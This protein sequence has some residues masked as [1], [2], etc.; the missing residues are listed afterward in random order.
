MIFTHHLPKPDPL[1]AAILLAY[2]MDETLCVDYLLQEL[3]LTEEARE[4][5][6][7]TARTL[8]TEVRKR[9]LHKNGLDAFLYQYDLSSEEG[10]ALMCLAEALLR[11]PD[12]AT[13]A[14]LIRDKISPAAWQAQLG[15]SESFFVNAATWGLMLTGKILSYQTLNE[16]N[17]AVALKKLVSHTSEPV[18]RSAVRHSMKI[19]GHQFVMGQ[20]IESALKR[21]K[22][23]EKL[24]YS[25]SYDMLGEAARTAEDAERYFAAYWHAIQVIGKMAKGKNIYAAPGVSIKLS[26]LYPRYELAQHERCVPFVVE[27]LRELALQAKAFNISF[28][29]D[30]EEADRLELSLDIIE[31]VFTD[32]LLRDWEGF[33]V[34]VQAYQKRAMPLID[35][36]AELARSQHRRLMLRLVKGAYWDYE[37][38]DSQVKGLAG[39]PVFT[40]KRN[41]DVSY[42]ACVKRIA[43]AQDAFFPQFAT[44]NAHTVAAVLEIMGTRRDF[45][46]QCLHGMGYTLYDHIVPLEKKNIPCRVYAPVGGHEDLLSYLVRR[47]LENG[48][49]T[50]FVNRIVDANAPIKG[51]VADPIEMVRHFGS[52]PHPHIPLP[53]AVFGASRQNSRGIDFTD[54]LELENLALEMTTAAKKMWQATPTTLSK[55]VRHLKAEAV[56]SPSNS[57]RQV[58]VVRDA[59]SIEVNLALEYAHHSS[60]AWDHLSI[61]DRAACLERAADLFEQHRAELIT[62][63]VLEAGKCLPDATG[64]VREATDYC[65]YYAQQA[66]EKLSTQTLPGPTGESNQLQMHGRGVIA[67]ISP[68]NFPLAIFIGQVVAA[69]VAGNTVIAK[70]AKQTPLIAAR[71]IQLLHQVGIPETVVQLLPGSGSVIGQALL[72]DPRI[73]GIVFTGST[74]T[75]R[76]INQTLASR[77]GEIIPLIAETGGQNAMIVDSSALLEQVVTDVITSAFNSAGQRCSALRVLFIQEEV[78]DRLLALLQGAMAE[79]QVGDPSLLKTDIGPVIDQGAKE[80]LEKHI[81]YLETVGYLIY[82]V[83]LANVCQQGTFF[84]PCAYEIPNLSVLTHEVFGP[85]LHVIRYSRRRLDNVIAAINATGY[86]LTLGIH[87]RIDE[88]I[89]YI[90]ERMPVGNTYVNRNM[91]GAV[92]G[93]QPFGGERLSGTG[94]KAGGPHYLFRFCNERTLTINTTAAGG[95]ASL[96][97]LGE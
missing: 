75:A 95:N 51:L 59:N 85:I 79:L 72:A 11:V 55:N 65:R 18:I 8:V 84:A 31:A 70:P 37:I 19:L 6:D 82:R 13:A 56:V 24:G 76:I 2:R 68:W 48:A 36:L 86:G 30:A 89:R 80:N 21:A 78:A 96:L 74:A 73:K 64:E 69:L 39:Y 38:K 42:L 28:S 54:R 33:G 1:R 34:V 90:Q 9:R 20:T 66:R 27:R 83:P 47:L 4:R 92:V 16:K 93:V 10:I 71:A 41:T 63:L 35:W 77:E 49:N 81:S 32:P 40:R 44:H 58:G 97:T 60:T 3:I 52:K 29:I 88:T 46:F 25:F 45:E 53:I 14:C 50:S 57:M 23:Y 7:L 91:I 17:L 15:K 87:S 12:R 22:S 61:N 94:P 67:C 5:I 26:A 43:S 62:L